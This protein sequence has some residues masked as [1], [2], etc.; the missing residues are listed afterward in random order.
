MQVSTA[1]RGGLTS[2]I[3]GLFLSLPFLPNLTITCL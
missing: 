3:A 2:S 1:Q